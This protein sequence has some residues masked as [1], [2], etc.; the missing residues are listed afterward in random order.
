MANEGEVYFALFGDDF[1]PGEV[2]KLVGLQPT[3]VRRK[4][5][6]LPKHAWWKVSIGKT[7]GELVDVYEMSSALIEKLAPHAQGI[8]RA[9]QELRLEAILEVVLHISMNDSIPT[10]AIG[11]TPEVVSFLSR[12]GAGIDID[13]YRNSL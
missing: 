9:K 8:L 10:P 12:V 7:E 1:D 3:S 5:Y 13:A 4:T 11:F 6:P 2:T